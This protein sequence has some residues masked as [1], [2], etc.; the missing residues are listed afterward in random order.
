MEKIVLDDFARRFW[1]EKILAWERGRYHIGKD[2]AGGLLEAVADRLSGSL[3]FRLDT[4]IA[5]VEPL[6]RGRSVLELGCGSGLLANR[7]LD[8]GATDYL[9]VD[10]ASVAIDAAEARRSSGQVAERARFVCSSLDDLSAISQDFV[11]SLG[12]LDW[13]TDHQLDHLFRLQGK[14]DFLHAIA[15][16]SNGVAQLVHRGYV[17]IAYGWRTKTYRPRYYSCAGIA[18]MTRTHR[19]PGPIYVFRHHRLTFGALVSSLPIGAPL[20]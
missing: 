19:G 18:A 17:Q 16:R 14:A 2:N 10:I 7:F 15:E 4:A 5:L 3:R 6:M 9:G 1:E 12:L 11:F 20:D 8:A 13:L